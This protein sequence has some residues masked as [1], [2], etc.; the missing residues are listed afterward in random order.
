MKALA[1]FLVMAGAAAAS[2]DPLGL[3]DYD[4]IIAA[5]GDE[6]RIVAGGQQLLVLPGGVEL[7]S[8]ADGRLISARDRA[9]AVGC[10]LNA[11]AELTAAAQSCAGAMTPGQADGMDSA[12]A[13]LIPAYGAGV[14][15]EPVPEAE[16]TERFNALVRAYRQAPEICDLSTA[17]RA[18]LHLVGSEAGRGWIEAAAAAPRLPVSE[19]CF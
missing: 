3:V 2:A 10:A 9:G 6:A 4:A 16:V 5:N 17:A 13:A 14:L 15:P 8:D 18:V 7:L 11:L 19:P 12:V 1:A